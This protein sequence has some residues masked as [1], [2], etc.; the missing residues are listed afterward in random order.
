MAEQDAITAEAIDRIWQV[1]KSTP[2]LTEQVANLLAGCA[3]KLDK[4]LQSYLV[5]KVQDIPIYDHNSHTLSI[6]SHD[7]PTLWVPLSPL[8]PI[9]FFL[10]VLSCFALMSTISNALPYLWQNC[11]RVKRRP[12]KRGRIKSNWQQR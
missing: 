9:F 12:M 1:T 8:P 4:S 2:A 5:E 10:L 11:K 7:T 3:P 6:I